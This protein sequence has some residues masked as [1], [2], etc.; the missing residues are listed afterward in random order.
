MTNQPK[1]NA[2]VVSDKEGKPSFMKI[3]AAWETMGGGYNIRL[4]DESQG[5]IYLFQH[6][7]RKKI[8]KP[9][10]RLVKPSVPS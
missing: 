10:E 6:K 5:D 8:V 7:E 3:G 1:F 4:E 9:N 2:F